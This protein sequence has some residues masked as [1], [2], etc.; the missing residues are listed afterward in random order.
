M[1]KE[2]D[3]AFGYANLN[4]DQMAEWGYISIKELLENGAELDREWKP[5]TYL[6]TRRVAE[7]K[8]K[9]NNV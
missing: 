1:R 7:E 3:L 8:R 5:C 6:E 2:E 4:D 9:C